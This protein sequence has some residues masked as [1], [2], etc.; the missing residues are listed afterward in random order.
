MGNCTITGWVATAIIEEII[1]EIIQD[2]ATLVCRSLGEGQLI[3]SSQH[4]DLNT[5][6]NKK[7]QF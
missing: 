5:L 7:T 1:E 3:M 2:L 6:L 4:S